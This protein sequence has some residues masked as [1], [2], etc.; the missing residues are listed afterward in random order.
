VSKNTVGSLCSGVN[1]IPQASFMSHLVMTALM[2][3][4]IHFQA[5]FTEYVREDEQF[6]SHVRSDLDSHA[7]SSCRGGS[8]SD[9]SADSATIS[10][11]TR[12][13]PAQGCSRAIDVVLHRGRPAHPMPDNF[14]VHLNGNPLPRSIRAGWGCQ[15]KRR[16]ALDKVEEVLRETPNRAV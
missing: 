6:S 7:C 8:S 9:A 3:T 10:H 2:K 13:I 1:R 12:R 16:V 14:S 4:S 15:L 11:P 5:S